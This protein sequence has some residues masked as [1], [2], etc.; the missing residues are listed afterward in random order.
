MSSIYGMEMDIF[1]KEITTLVTRLTIALFLDII[2][3]LDYAELDVAGLKASRG[4][5]WAC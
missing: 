2:Q 4:K 3:S 5:S 1:R